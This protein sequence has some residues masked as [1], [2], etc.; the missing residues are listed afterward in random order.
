MVRPSRCD[1]R[2]V[3]T[4]SWSATLMASWIPRS[5]EQRSQ[6]ARE[7]EMPSWEC[8]RHPSRNSPGLRLSTQ[9][10]V[11]P[12]LFPKACFSRQRRPPALKANTLWRV[13]AG[14]RECGSPRHGPCPAARLCPDLAARDAE[15]RFASAN[16]LN[17]NQG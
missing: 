13:F 16:H 7:V 14:E 6:T 8:N 15:R 3:L 17:Q 11:S 10:K 4:T 2:A 1:V 9:R 12:I 5:R